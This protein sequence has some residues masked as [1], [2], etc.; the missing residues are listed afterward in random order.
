MAVTIYDVAKLASVSVTTISKILNHKDYDISDETRQR[1]MKVIEEVNFI[2]SSLARSLVTKRTN[3]LGLLLPDISN[4]YFADMARGV[5]DG[6]N[7]FGYNVMLCNTDD[8]AN[9]ELDY[10]N[11]L[12]G[13]ETDGII[14]IPIAGLQNALTSGFTFEKPF[15]VLDRVLADPSGGLYQVKFD[16]VKGGYLAT[17]YLIEKGHRRIG[18][19]S[20]PKG[21][22]TAEDR[23]NGYKAAISES[24]IEF[25]E[26][27]VFYGN[28]KFDSGFNG[29]EVLMRAGVTAIFAINDMM[30]SGVYK[31]IL[32]RGLKIPRDFSIIGYDNVALSELLDPPLTTIS[33]PKYEMGKVAAAMLIN[34]LRKREQEN[35]VVFEP[36]LVERQSVRQI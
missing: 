25:D 9:K 23:L 1:V 19:I 3:V 27:I 35:E 21:D 22:K 26:S 20:G 31:A 17:K 5:E 33:Q 28:Y 24:K 14:I 32:L 36:S 13:R 34:R 6:A 16:N 4:L 7:R 11:I 10:L 15:V 30:A 12:R 29:A 8:N 2:P 18:I